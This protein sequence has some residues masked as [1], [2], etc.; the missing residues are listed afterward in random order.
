MQSLK[1]SREPRTGRPAPCQALALQ[2]RGMTAPALTPARMRFRTVIP[3]WATAFVAAV[4]IGVLAPATYLEWMPI[5]MA[6]LVLLTF[7]LQLIVV[8]KEGLVDRMTASM[9]GSIGILTAA[10]I[11]L[12]IVSAA[13]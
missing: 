4:L 10:T 7:A 8:Q 9:V 1:S 11:V 5:A 12:A 13:R 2:N 3:V 6:G